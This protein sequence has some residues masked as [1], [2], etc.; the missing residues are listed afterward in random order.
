MGNGVNRERN[1]D[2]VFNL[3]N[4]VSSNTD[5]R[6]V[7]YAKNAKASGEMARFIQL[8]IER[9][10]VLTKTEVDLIISK[11]FD[12]FGHAGEEYAQY[13]IQNIHKVK[14]EL[15][16]M[17]QKIDTLMN[18]RGSD[19]KYSTCLSAVFL[20]AIIAKRLNIHNIPI[21]PVLQAVANEFKVFMQDLKDND[22]DAV[23]TLGNFLGENVARNTLVINGQA[24]TRTGLGSAPLLKPM[25]DLNIRFEP[26]VKTLYIP[27]AVIKEYLT[28]LGVE[29]AD[30]VKS[31]KDQK[32]LLH[33]KGTNKIMHK[34]LGMSGPPVRCL[35][36][37]S[38][39][40][41]SEIPL[42]VPKNVN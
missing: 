23:E 24:D 14:A 26:D 32:L 39:K 2:T 19:R 36:I 22:F 7:I 33:A 38:T 8:R 29:Y 41:E 21:Q 28:K 13:L 6:T 4:V 5:F 42:D 15:Q 35:W 37:D 27:C 40:F 31:L 9:D 16:Q 30:F 34:G 1:N 20:G 12:N 18:F 17:Q 10:D 3:I 11:I 25:G